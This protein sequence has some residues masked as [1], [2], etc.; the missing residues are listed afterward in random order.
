VSTN[1]TAT[2]R[3]TAFSKEQVAIC[4]DLCGNELAAA[5]DYPP[6]L[7]FTVDETGLAVVQNKQ[8]KILT[9]KGTRQTGAVTSHHKGFHNDSCCTHQ[10]HWNSVSS[11]NFTVEM[12]PYGYI[13]SPFLTVPQSCLVTSDSIRHFQP[14]F[15]KPILH[16]SC[17]NCYTFHYPYLTILG[18]LR[19]LNKEQ[20]IISG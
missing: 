20:Q 19:L 8:T 4:C 3:A 17:L 18:L 12:L 5:V 11:P 15:H 7:V 2:A 14:L 1:R 13:P 10:C 9:P 6:S 16:F